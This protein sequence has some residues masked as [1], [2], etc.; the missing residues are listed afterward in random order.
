MKANAL[1]SE[2]TVALTSESTVERSENKD[3]GVNGCRLHPVA[4][5][6]P[7]MDEKAFEELVQDIRDNGLREPVV[8]DQHG[9]IVDGA[10]RYRACVEAQVEPSFEHREFKDDREVMPYVVSKNLM[11]RQLTVSQRAMIAADIANRTRGGDQSVKSPNGTSQAEAAEMMGVSPRTVGDAAKIREVPDVAAK[12]RAGHK[13]VN[14]A[15]SEAQARK[16]TPVKAPKAAATVQT[17]K[18]PLPKPHQI[19][20]ALE[21]AL[22]ELPSALKRAPLSP[23]DAALFIESLAAAIKQIE[24]GQKD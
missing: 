2:S 12:V 18:L 16:K 24:A 5:L 4:A 1:T 22:E 17:P 21:K 23:G 20:R 13:T 7:P 6:F 19:Y 11:R 15:I 8:L 14:A 10:Q 3:F 9:Q